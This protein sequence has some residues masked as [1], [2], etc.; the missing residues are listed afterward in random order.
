[1]DFNPLGAER[2]QLWQKTKEIPAAAKQARK[3]IRGASALRANVP[4]NQER[5]AGGDARA[6]KS[7]PLDAAVRNSKP[8]APNT[9]AA[10]RTRIATRRSSALPATPVW[11]SPLV[12][13][14]T[15]GYYHERVTV[16]TCKIPEARR[17]VR[18][19][20]HDVPAAD[21]PRRFN[22]SLEHLILLRLTVSKV[23]LE[24]QFAGV[25]EMTPNLARL[26]AS[27]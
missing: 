24:F 8:A 3:P 21:V 18:S 14:T 20:G 6:T 10:R 9:T 4:A 12:L 13:T 25:C 1:M 23:R 11:V 5:S 2:Y 16:I 22:R 15:I 19:G 7:I 26:S 17:R 27:R